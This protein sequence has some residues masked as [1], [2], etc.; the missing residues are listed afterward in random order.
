MIDNPDDIVTRQTASKTSAKLPFLVTVELDL[1][2]SGD[3]DLGSKGSPVR[4]GVADTVLKRG[5][6]KLRK[7]ETQTY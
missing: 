7:R 1:D 6:T 5:L 2:A 3:F 4:T